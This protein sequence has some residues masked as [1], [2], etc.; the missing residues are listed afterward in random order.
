MDE[1]EVP[2]DSSEEIS[3]DGSDNKDDALSPSSDA[4]SSPSEPI[5]KLEGKGINNEAD[6]EEIGIS[7]APEEL[8]TMH[9]SDVYAELAEFEKAQNIDDHH[10][11]QFPEHQPASD[12]RPIEG[13]EEA[14]NWLE[15]L[16][17][18]QGIPIDEMPTLVTNQPKPDASS[19]KGAESEPLSD[20]ESSTEAI[21]MDSDPMAWLEQLAV[22]QSSPL[23]ELP[24]VADRLL[25]SE[26]VS[27]NEIP[28]S[29]TINDP[30]D[31]DRALT[32]L[33]QLAVA[34]GIDL[35][36]VS[37]DANQPVNSLNSALAIIDRLALAGMATPQNTPEARSVDDEDET[38]IPVNEGDGIDET[39]SVDEW[40]MVSS[41]MPDDPQQALDWLGVIDS[42]HD[43][44]AIEVVLEDD[45]LATKGDK[46]AQVPAEE[47]EMPIGVDV[48]HEMPEDPD[49]A[50]A[51][52]EDLAMRKFKKPAPKAEDIKI[53]DDEDSPPTPQPSSSMSDQ[54]A[55]TRANPSG[56]DL[57]TTIAKYQKII[58]EE[59]VTEGDVETLEAFIESHGESPKLFRLLGDAYMQ[60]GQTE[61]AIATYRKGFDHF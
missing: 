16:A 52:M 31:I 10:D 34:Q 12:S 24:S 19:K 33:E 6:K 41:N 22:D 3:I 47:E 27:Q 11:E 40:S 56:S 50:V 17:A 5:N 43:S 20:P 60:I 25:A 21:E 58:D 28:P 54:T 38:R 23:E 57:Q 61:K 7:T 29:S 14:M 55:E 49:E 42:T 9:W 30:Y 39:S 4:Q 2:E 32:Y 35:S 44:D 1:Q 59:S 8:P 53:E 51:W 13:V 48:L 45:T 46:T 26:I 15:E 37:F 36:R 18:G